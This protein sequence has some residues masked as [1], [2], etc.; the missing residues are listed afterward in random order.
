MIDGLLIAAITSC[1]CIGILVLLFLIVVGFVG[2][3]M[4]ERV[5]DFSK[6]TIVKLQGGLLSWI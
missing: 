5:S 1:A 6:D 3:T 4:F 2:M